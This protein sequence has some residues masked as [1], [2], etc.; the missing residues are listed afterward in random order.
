MFNTKVYDTLCRMGLI[1][2]AVLLA[3]DA[4]ML[5]QIIAWFR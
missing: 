1:A 2:I 3:C 5:L 4:V